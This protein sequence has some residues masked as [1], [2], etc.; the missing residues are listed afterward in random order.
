MIVKLFNGIL[1]A[2]MRQTRQDSSIDTHIKVV[3]V[4][5][6]AMLGINENP[7]EARD[8]GYGLGQRGPRQA[9]IT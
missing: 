6:L 2:F 4:C 1:S 3:P 9:I 5:N 8:S 7:V